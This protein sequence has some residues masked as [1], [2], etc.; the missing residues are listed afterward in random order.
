MLK[1]LSN[2]TSG[3]GDRLHNS[4]NDPVKPRYK[5]PDPQTNRYEYELSNI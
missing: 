3:V 4:N 2:K 5:G 1:D